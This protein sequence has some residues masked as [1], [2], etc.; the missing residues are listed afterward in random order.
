M[1]L[2]AAQDSIAEGKAVH[3]PAAVD[4]SCFTLTSSEAPACTHSVVFAAGPKASIRSAVMLLVERIMNSQD[5]TG[6]EGT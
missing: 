4:K 2:S 6:K 1:N 5:H 3:A